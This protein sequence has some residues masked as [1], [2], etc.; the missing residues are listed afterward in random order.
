LGFAAAQLARPQALV[1]K[2]KGGVSVSKK[3][4]CE[5]DAV[6]VVGGDD[7]GGLLVWVVSNST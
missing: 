6:F 7:A 3:V 5:E 2:D 1:I 4:R